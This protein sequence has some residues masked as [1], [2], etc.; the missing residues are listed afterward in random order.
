MLSKCC[1]I[2]SL[3]GLKYVAVR[4]K[5]DILKKTKNVLE[6]G[7][8]K[9][10]KERGFR[11]IFPCDVILSCSNTGCVILHKYTKGAR[12]QSRAC[13]RRWGY[14]SAQSPRSASRPKCH[15]KLFP[16]VAL[17]QGRRRIKYLTG[18]RF[19]WLR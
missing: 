9:S 18:E 19:D 6:K 7:A 8:R 11:K 14:E 16:W 1:S 2:C 3:A 13:H 12:E 5:H 15:F 17:V 10:R 4:K